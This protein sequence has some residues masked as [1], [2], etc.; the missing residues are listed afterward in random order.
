MVYITNLGAGASRLF[1]PEA[2][3]QVKARVHLMILHAPQQGSRWSLK[4]LLEA[5]QDWLPYRGVSGLWQA[6]KRFG[7]SYQRARPYIHSP[8]DEYEAKEGFI[9]QVLEQWRQ[10]RKVV[11]FEDEFTFYNEASVASAFM[12]KS[13]QPLAPLPYSPKSRR[14]AGALNPFTG[15]VSTYQDEK[16]GYVELACFFEQLCEEYPKAETIF[17]ILDNW[18]IHFHPSLQAA[19]VDQ[20]HGFKLH[21]PPSWDKLKPERKFIGMDL[22]IQMVPLPTYASWLNPIEKLWK[23]LKQHLLHLHPYSS[24]FKEL[25]CQ[26]NLFL[27]K[28]D[29]VSEGLLAY[30]GLLKPDG[31][32][33]DSL[34]TAGAPFLLSPD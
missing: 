34:R 3:A 16:I 31:I 17:L 21:L 13:R 15:K 33:A 27:K 14:I 1:P 5:C 2:E 25:C 29:Q 26:V 8:D 7:I 20:Q 12:P 30:C 23:L 6:L 28:F 9:G 4:S 10:G 18:P 11:L 19:L 32:F 24:D 22:P